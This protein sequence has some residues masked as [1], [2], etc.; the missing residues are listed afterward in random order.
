MRIGFVENQRSL[1]VNPDNCPPNFV[2]EMGAV[3]HNFVVK[4]KN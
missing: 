2:K 4:P 3:L 1:T